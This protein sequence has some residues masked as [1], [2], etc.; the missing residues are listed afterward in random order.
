MYCGF[1]GKKLY[2]VCCLFSFYSFFLLWFPGNTWCDQPSLFSLLFV[3]FFVLYCVF[4]INMFSTRN[5][6]GGFKFPRLDRIATK[7]CEQYHISF[8][9]E[10][11]FQ[12]RLKYCIQW[13]LKKNAFKNCLHK[14]SY[15]I[16]EP[17]KGVTV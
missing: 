15:P 4:C 14:V 9:C 12:L 11:I 10:V 7:F 3:C 16:K 2:L 5:Q 8:L 17:V 6:Y 13:C 1:I